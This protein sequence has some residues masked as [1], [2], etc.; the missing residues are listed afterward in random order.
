MAMRE[1]ELKGHIIDSFILPKVFDTI[2]DMDGDFEVMEFEIGKKKEETSYARILIK[3]HDQ[4]H[5]DQILG[6]LH[7]TGAY[8]PEIEEVE[9]LPAPKEKA[10]PDDFYSTTNHPT[11]IRYEGEW[12][13]VKDIEMDCMIVIDAKKKEALCKPISEIKK[14][15]SVVIGKKGI[16]VIPPE[17]PRGRIGVFEFMISHVSTEKPSP[18]II[19]QIAKEMYDLKKNGEK[20][21]WVLGPAV[22]HTGGS[23]YIAQ[24]IR[25]GYVDVLLSGN[26][27]AVHDVECSLFGTSLGMDITYGR[28]SP[29]GHRHHILA[30]NTIMKAG[31]IENAI[32]E[33]ILKKGI[34]YECIKNNVPFVLAG[35]IRDDGP[36]PEVITDV[37]EAQ[38]AMREHLKDVSMVLMMASMLHSIAVGN[39]LKSHVKTVCV[40]INP[41]TVTK[42]TDRGTAQALGVVTDVGVFLPL[43]T[44]ELKKL[45]EE[46]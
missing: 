25:N 21:A 44:T 20:I 28:P 30:I 23:E 8:V 35:S 39:L 9:F 11:Y 19:Q 14:G 6:E 26:A 16:R 46:K 38:D 3:G 15:E 27:L 5:L 32:K 18:S 45:D 37:M 41:A 40:D 7:K 24:L 1:I 36:L 31:S 43:L 42:L 2:M 13:E 22:I 29:G 12:L 33:N 4:K 17:R 10:V 34:M